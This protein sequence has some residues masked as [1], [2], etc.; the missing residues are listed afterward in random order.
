MVLEWFNAQVAVEAGTSLADKFAP[1]I[2]SRSVG[3]A[4][5]GRSK[6]TGRS[7]QGIFDR[8]DPEIRVLRL[9][10]YKR[11]KFANSFKWRLIENGVEKTVA[12][13]VTHSVLLRLSANPARVGSRQHRNAGKSYGRTR[14]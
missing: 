14:P 7:L 5:K 1:P 8:L 10:F 2:G 4:K 11:V 6:D 3:C 12:D 13:Q 9:N